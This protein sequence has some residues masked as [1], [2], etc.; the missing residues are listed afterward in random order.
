MPDTPLIPAPWQLEG[1]GYILLYKF[2]RSDISTM[3]FI[4]E[5]LKKRFAGGLGALMIV[6]YKK[7]DAGPY[8]ELLFI[9][10]RFRT[11]KWKRYNIPK[12][13]VSTRTSVVNGITNWAIP[14]EQA[15]FTFTRESKN[16]R[17]IEVRTH[18]TP[19]FSI[20]LKE[21]G[22]AFPVNTALLPFPLLQEKDGRYYLTK[23]TGKGKGRFAG[24]SDIKINPC[25]FPDITIRKP[26]IAISVSPFS[27]CFPAAE[28]FDTV[29][30]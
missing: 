14:K 28:I 21:K 30:Y 19:F 18:D 12:I 6:D 16:S 8:S 17:H 2:T 15:E 26:L 22:F 7:S 13:Y 10:G 25:F 1:E 24:I 20:T 5:S 29:I 23:F 9:P 11:G 27:I 3:A 4:D